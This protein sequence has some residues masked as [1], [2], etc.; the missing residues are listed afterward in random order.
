[1]ETPATIHPAGTAVYDHG[2]H[3]FAEL[4]EPATQG[5]GLLSTGSVLI[6]YTGDAAG[7]TAMVSTGRLELAE[8]VEARWED[9]AASEHAADPFGIFL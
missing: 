5:I 7:S 9:T 4:L 2:T 1:M 8:H 3:L 6:R